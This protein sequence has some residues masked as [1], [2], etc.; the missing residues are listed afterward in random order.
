FLALAGDPEA[1]PVLEEALG[2]AQRLQLDEVYSQALSSRAVS[3]LREGRLDEAVTLLR[4]ALEVALEGDFS[5]AVF[6]AWNNLAVTLESEDRYAEEVGLIAPMLDMSRRKGD[7]ASE[8]TALLGHAAPLPQ[9]GRWDEALAF[10]DEARAAEELEALQWAASR[11]VVLVLIHVRRGDLETARQGF[12]VAKARSDEHNDEI[13]VHVGAVEIELLN[14]EGKHAEALS[15]A[16]QFLDLIPLFG[17]TNIGLKGA[18]AHGVDAAFELGDLEAADALLAVVHQASPGLV[19]PSLRGQAARLGARARA[20]RGDHDS[21]EAGFVAAIAEFRDLGMPFDLGV[22]LLEFAEWLD[23]EGRQEDVAAFGL[24]SRSLFEQLGA[25]PWLDR[26][27]RLLA[28]GST[29]P[30]ATAQS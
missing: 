9:L 28:R 30:L 25:R 5:N 29:M 7:R 18:I 21:V 1:A 10:V 26:L 14:A 11:V 20:L 22:V 19:T 2:L 3:I 8:L 27:E 15:L 24:E 4:R 16:T 23:G 17:L 13:R 6:R 12:D